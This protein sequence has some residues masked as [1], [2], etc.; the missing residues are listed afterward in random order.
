MRRH[1][2]AAA[3]TFSA[4]ALAGCSSGSTPSTAPAE[5]PTA[6][7]SSPAGTAPSLPAAASTAPP[8]GASAKAW[9]QSGGKDLIALLTGDIANLSTDDGNQ[10][11]DM[12][13][14]DC[15]QL[16]GDVSRAQA[17]APVPDPRAQTSWSSALT[18]LHQGY[19]DCNGGYS[20]SDTAEVA[21]GVAEIK[22][23]AAALADVT[24]RVSG[25]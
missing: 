4:L 5:Q 3:I 19:M 8:S 7:P 14:T 11:S 25:G 24:T 22:S 21:K 1:T 15:I 16:T 23:A 13:N 12:V 6:A 2:T 17:Y 18:T 20:D 9:Y 10:D